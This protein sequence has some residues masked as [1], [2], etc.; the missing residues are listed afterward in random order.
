MR[1]VGRM[2]LPW[3]EPVKSPD[4]LVSSDPDVAMGCWCLQGIRF[5]FSSCGLKLRQVFFSFCLGVWELSSY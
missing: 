1:T 3:R 2:M 5:G 4:E